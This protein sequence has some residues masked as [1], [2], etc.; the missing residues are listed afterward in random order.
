M[1]HFTLAERLAKFLSTQH[2]CR[3]QPVSR[4]RPAKAQCRGSG[5]VGPFLGTDLTWGETH[6]GW[7]LTRGVAYLEVLAAPSHPQLGLPCGP[8]WHLGIA[9][10]HRGVRGPER[11]PGGIRLVPTHLDNALVH[12]CL[13]LVT[14]G[15]GL[16]CSHMV[17]LHPLLQRLQ[18]APRGLGNLWPEEVGRG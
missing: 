7:G 16:G 12:A 1:T 4:N 8:E 18:E 11:G 2:G 9:A 15:L 17:P 5:V 10:R 13:P 14:L 6:L 3:R